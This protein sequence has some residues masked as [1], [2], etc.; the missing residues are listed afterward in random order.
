MVPL[1]RR[2]VVSSSVGNTN[3]GSD[4]SG[5]KIPTKFPQVVLFLLERKMGASRRAFLSQLGEKKGFKVEE[6][7][8]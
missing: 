3:G 5:D 1:K 6:L 2:K 7:F 8:R 4:C